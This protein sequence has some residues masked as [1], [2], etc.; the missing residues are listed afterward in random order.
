[1]KEIFWEIKSKLV[2]QVFRSYLASQF[3]DHGVILF[4]V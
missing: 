4:R 2:K 3:R 1:L